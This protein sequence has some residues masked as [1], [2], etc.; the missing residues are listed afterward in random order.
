MQ[1]SKQLANNKLTVYSN[2]HLSSD[3]GSCILKMDE[4]D[5]CSLPNTAR[6]EP[7]WRERALRVFVRAKQ[8]FC[9]INII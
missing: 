2:D 8:D 6:G 7:S 5:P 4:P 1:E 3:P 9:L